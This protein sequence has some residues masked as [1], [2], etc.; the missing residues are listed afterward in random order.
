MNHLVNCQSGQSYGVPDRT[1]YFPFLSIEFKSQA[2]GG[3]HYVAANQAAGA[4]AI[5]LNGFLELHERSFGEQQPFDSN[6]PLFFSLTLDD[7]CAQINVHWASTEPTEGGQPLRRFNVERLAG[8]WLGDADGWR[9]V[10][11]I[12]R[13]ILHYGLSERLPRLFAV[14]D[15]YQAS[16]LAEKATSIGLLKG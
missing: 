3:T 16:L 13:N 4:G 15:A 1:L 7:A 10:L 12:V 6:E 8:H 11:R 14:L 5:A 9:A 2:K